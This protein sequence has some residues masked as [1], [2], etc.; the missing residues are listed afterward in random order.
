[1]DTLIAATS[2]AG[3]LMAIS[4]VSVTLNTLLLKGFVPSIRRESRHDHGADIAHGPM[5]PAATSGK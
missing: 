2:L 1:M 3:A 5:V 4:S